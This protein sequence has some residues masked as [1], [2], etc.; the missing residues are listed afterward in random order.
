MFISKISSLFVVCAVTIVQILGSLVMWSCLLTNCCVISSWLRIRAMQLRILFGMRDLS[1]GEKWFRELLMS[2]SPEVSFIEAARGEIKS[3]LI[4]S[5]FKRF[6]CGYLRRCCHQ[7]YS[8]FF[9]IFFAPDCILDVAAI[10][11]LEPS[12]APSLMLPSFRCVHPFIRLC[13]VATAPPL[14]LIE[15]LAVLRAN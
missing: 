14:H 11:L 8:K 6:V 1:I 3:H 15:G 7:Y 12:L 10:D 2:I 5:I 9:E 13:W 4:C